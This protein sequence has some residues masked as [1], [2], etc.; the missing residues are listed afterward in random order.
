MI[1]NIQRFSI[2]DGPGV[3]TTVF[4]KGCPLSCLWCHN[5]EGQSAEP[6]LIFRENRCDACGE[7]A[8]VCPVRALSLADGLLVVDEE[9]CTQCGR[10]VAACAAGAL[11]LAG[12]EATVAEVMVEVEKDRLFYDQSGGGVTL[13]GGEPLLQPDF[14]VELLRA[15]REREI[16]TA[17]DTTGHA[18]AE[19]VRRVAASV[20]LFLYDL[21]LVDGARHRALTGVPNGLILENLRHLV[22]DGRTVI[23]RVP[24]IPGVNDDEQNLEQIG[25]LAR[26]LSGRQRI[27]LLAYHHFAAEKYTRLRREY[28]LPALQPP[29]SQRMAEIAAGLAGLGLAVNIGG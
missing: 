2:H 24:I 1:F 14:L 26:S 17:L 25:G 4:L 16:H 5:P 13:S 10:C 7:C 21:K 20:D 19:V 6:Q 23:L 8:A 29:S 12:R 11:E 9:T 28:R 3:R 18:P 15:C 22:R 27:D